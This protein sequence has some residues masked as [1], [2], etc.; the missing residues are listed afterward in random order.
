MQ[1][2]IK[3]LGS[4][5]DKYFTKYSCIVLVVVDLL[6]LMTEISIPFPTHPSHSKNILINSGIDS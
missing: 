5:G 2:K 3:G 4:R 1:R 6:L